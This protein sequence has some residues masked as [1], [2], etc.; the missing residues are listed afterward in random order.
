MDKKV[1]ELLKLTKKLL[2]QSMEIVSDSLPDTESVPA[3]EVRYSIFLCVQMSEALKFGYGAYYSCKHGWGHGGIGAARSIYEILLDIKYINQ[4]KT[5]K[6]ERFTR[7]LDHGAEYL[8]RKM[9]RIQESGQ[10]VSQKDQDKYTNAYGQLKKKYN[11]KRR[12]EIDSGAEKADATPKYRQYNW[13]GLNLKEKAD[14]INWEQFHQLYKD[15]SNLSHVSIDTTL[16][17]IIGSAQNQIEVD[18]SLYSSPVHCFT[19]LTVAFTC[20]AGILEEY[21]GYFGI[22]HSCYPILADF[23][24]DYKELLDR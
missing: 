12:Q 23:W 5:S 18:L 14:A 13:A 4:D 21:M 6:E 15:L 16:D 22:D 9:E 24:N 2:D 10:T 11:D 8:Y 20:I 3:E 1:P 17:A 7:F 19:V